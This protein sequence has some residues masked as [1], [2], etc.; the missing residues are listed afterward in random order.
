MTAYS[1]LG[2]GAVIDG[3]T[4]VGNPVLKEIGEK[5]GKSSA[6]VAI[7]WLASRGLVVI[8]KSVTPARVLQNREVKFELSAE[9]IGKIGR[10]AQQGLPERLGRSF[11][12]GRVAARY[13]A[14]LVSLRGGAAGVLRSRSTFLSQTPRTLDTHYGQGGGTGG[15]Q[16]VT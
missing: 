8:P 4:V 9:D 5:Y 3:S 1:P 12:R 10:R 11:E 15:L 2:T 6:Q 7:C 16:F 13:R 14:P